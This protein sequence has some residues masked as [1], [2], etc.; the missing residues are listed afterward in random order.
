MNSR[1]EREASIMKE[2]LKS[3]ISIY[4]RQAG[5]ENVI[6]S[7]V[8]NQMVKLSQDGLKASCFCI[9]KNERS[10]GPIRLIYILAFKY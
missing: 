8:Y 3:S 2:L 7:V 5:Y 1:I 9:R 10:E 6:N 4:F